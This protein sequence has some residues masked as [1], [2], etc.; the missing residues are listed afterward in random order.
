MKEPPVL[1]AAWPEIITTLTD[2]S[3]ERYRA[4]VYENPD[5]VRYFRQATPI[6]VIER[7]Q[8]G[9]RPS[10]RRSR[11]GIEN[12]RAIP[13]VFAW[14]QVRIGLPGTFGAG[15]GF[16]KAIEK[17]GLTAVQEMLAWPFFSGLINDV[18]MVLAK[19]DLEIGQRYS[20]LAD[21]DL[22]R[23]H[24]EIAT[25]LQLT[26]KLL[27]DIKQT[28]RLLDEDPTLRRAIRLR[29]PYVDPLNLLQIELLKDWRATDR[30][31]DAMLSALFDTVNGIAR[32]VQNTG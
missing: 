18:E 15:T 21:G 13:W 14:A 25:E 12:L 29:N 20:M 11:D 24:D 32:G 5:F 7:L 19:S 23:V 27:L 16:A 3:R 10:A 31:D 26:Q 2:A 1:G 8:I 17:H 4:L 22:R 9:S 30:Q 28:D 6:D